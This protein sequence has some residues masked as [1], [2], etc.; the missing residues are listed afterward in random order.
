MKKMIWI[1]VAAVA[2]MSSAAFA[3]ESCAGVAAG[4]KAYNEK[5]YERAIDEW[6]TCV[7]NG[8]EDPDLY[9]NLGNAYFRNGKLGFAVYYYKSALR[10]RPNDPDIQHNLGFATAMTKD[11]VEE[12]EEENPL[13]SGLF[14]I[15]HALS[16]KVQ[17]FILL[18]LFWCF[19]IF[20]IARRLTG[21]EK[22]RN[23]LVGSSFILVFAFCI[24]GASA[25]YKIFIAETEAIGV[26]TAADADVTSAPDHKSQTL[27]TLSEGTSFEVLSEQGQFLE[28]KLGDRIKGFVHKKDVGVIK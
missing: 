3:N 27:N 10:L 5:D 24:T 26:V 20:A 21:N 22:T 23:I 25:G 14:K 15:H 11:K 28:I 12:D 17:L 7:D 8:M 9:Y 16:L 19:V 4:E 1:L 18:G 13:L 2:M 6:R